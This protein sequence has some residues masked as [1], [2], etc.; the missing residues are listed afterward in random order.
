MNKIFEDIALGKDL[1]AI[2]R[3]RSIPLNIL[4]IIRIRVE[5]AVHSED[6]ETEMKRVRLNATLQFPKYF[7]DEEIKT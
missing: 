1:E 3:E 6:M 2:V 7:P 5:K 4:I